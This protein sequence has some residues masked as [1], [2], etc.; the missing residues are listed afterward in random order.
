M[1]TLL[2]FDIDGT[3]LRAEG[4]TH[5]AMIKT[6]Q[7]L[8]DIQQSIEDISFLGRT[9]PELFK[10]VALKL[11]GRSLTEAE[12]TTVSERY[13]ALL[14][15]ELNGLVTF[16][17]MPGVKELLPFLAARKDII[18]G[19]ETGNLESA[20]Y[21]KLKRGGIGDYF[22]LGGFGS[23]SEDRTEIVRIGIERARSF[24][25]DSIPD[26][27]IFVIGDSPHDI[28]AGKSLGVNTIAV[29][30]GLVAQEK[31]LGTSPSYYFQDL[32]DIP[33]ILKCIGCEK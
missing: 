13:L 15:G 29:G 21:M 18:L 23:D 9:D 12:L 4:A 7:G 24:D 31:I 1:K 20:A 22:S 17:L 19:L 14:P 27:S 6:F 8:F 32:S 3:L 10:D 5:K 16:H 11:L 33:A 25:H 26:T 30:T 28:T 2:L